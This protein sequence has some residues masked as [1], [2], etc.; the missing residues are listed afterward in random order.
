MVVSLVKK[1][2]ELNLPLRNVIS[3][4]VEMTMIIYI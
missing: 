3:P 4:D 2:Y 1:T